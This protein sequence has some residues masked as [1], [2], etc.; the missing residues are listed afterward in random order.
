MK[1][2]SRAEPRGARRSRYE[3]GE[4][5]AETRE[6]DAKYQ[7]PRSAARSD[8]RGDGS[9]RS[10]LPDGRGSRALPGRLQGVRGAAREVRREARHRHAH[11][12]RGVR[13]HRHRG[14]DGRAAPHHRVHDV[15]LLGRRVRPD[16]QQRRQA[17]ADVRGAVHLPYRVPR[18]ERERQAGRKPALALHGALLRDHPGRQGRGPRVP[19]RRKGAPQG[20]GTG[21]EPG[22]R[23]GVGDAL[24]REGGCPRRRP[25]RRDRQGEGRARGDGRDA[26]GLL[27]HDAPGAR[28]CGGAGEGAREGRSDRSPV[29]APARRGDNRALRSQNAPLRR[30]ARGVA[31]RRRGGRNL[32]PRAAPRVG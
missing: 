30:R 1:A 5:R 21:R 29:A 28:G 23:D 16:P 3:S 14:R 24:R 4:Q 20:G 7:V 32:G 15:E 9:R 31:L 26:R 12:R 18:T 17:K 19:G 6:H 2:R 8:E 11:R 25:R 13:G 27:A 22:A 10:H